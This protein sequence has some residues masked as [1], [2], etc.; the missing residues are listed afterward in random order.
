MPRFLNNLDLSNVARVVNMPNPQNPQDAATK[1]YVD[2]IVEGLAWKDSVRTA[3][4]SNVN[5]SSPGA[6]IGGVTL[7]NGDRVLLFGQTNAAENG[8]YIFNGATSAMTRAPDANTAD[9]LEQAVVTV[10][11]GTFA[12]NTYRQTNVNFTLGTDPV[13]WTP[14]GTAA[15][16]ASET[17]AGIARIATQA[18]VNAGSADNLIVT[19][20]KLANWSGRIRKHTQT[21]G[22]G[23]NTQ[24][25]VTHNL[26]TRDVQVTVY[27]NASPYEVVLVDVEH[28]DNNTVTVR[29]AS[30][31]A[32]NAF[33]VVV[34]G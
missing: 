17:T 11:E 10:E 30:A 8:I 24:Y 26:G 4:N 2:S 1:A 27:R 12:G 31:P 34:I 6:S 29:F 20:L 3:S 16:A 21:V 33:R 28:T 7:S 15:P 32:S 19:P 22:D 25:S 13:N 5:I 18:E 14:F 9:E 23:T